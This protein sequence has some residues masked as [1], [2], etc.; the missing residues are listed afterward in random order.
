M[1]MDMN[2]PKSIAAWYRIAPNRHG[3][4]LA[5]FARIWPQFA[6]SIAE[7]GRILRGKRWQGPSK[8]QA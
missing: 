2:D 3:K 8:E 1:Q 6:A 4:A 5:V 7:A